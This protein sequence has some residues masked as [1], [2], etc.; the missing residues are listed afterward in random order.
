[1][2]HIF[3]VM[4]LTVVLA[5]MPV[6]HAMAA[7]DAKAP[8]SDVGLV[9][10]TA[11]EEGAASHDADAAEAEG[12]QAHDADGDAA[13]AAS[14]HAE[15]GL[16]QLNVS[17]YPSQIFWLAL[18]FGLLYFAFSKKILPGIGGVVE[19]RDSMIKGNLG[20]AE[21]LR[22]QAEEVRHSYEKNLE[23]ARANAIKAIQDVEMASKQ[24]ASDQA[25]SF[26]KKTDE[27]IKDAEV[28]VGAQKDKA[29][30]DMKQ[31]A[32][33]VASIAAEKITGINTDVQK[34]KAIVDS[35]A[36]KAKAA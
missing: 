3:F 20:M 23:A 32:A 34:A 18:S 16:P 33:E 11:T 10:A 4:A 21:N 7:A 36:D 14:D 25:E 27:T 30:G 15:G 28:R 6:Q 12:P 13:H 8:S 22:A 24:K 1:M 9:L 17:T 5:T 26:R 29:M 19:S 2:P 31:V 35:I